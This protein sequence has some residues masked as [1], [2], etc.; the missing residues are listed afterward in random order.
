MEWLQPGEGGDT[1]ALRLP[2]RLPD[3]YGS[4][5]FDIL[6]LDSLY[7]QAPVLQLAARIGW[8]AVIALKQERRDLYRNA[9]GMFRQRPADCRFTEKRHGGSCE[10][11]IG[12]TSGLPFSKDHPQPVRVVWSQEKVTGNQYRRRKLVAETTFQEWL[13]ITTLDAGAFPAPPVRALGHDRWKNENNGWNDLTQN[14]PLKHGFLHACKHR[15]KAGA[16]A[17]AAATVGG[18]PQLTANHGL[19]AVVLI[20]CTAFVLSSAFALIHSKIM[21]LRPLS[22]LE[23][24]RQLYRSLLRMLPP[25][26]APA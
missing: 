9:M 2:A 25:I 13:W 12:D 1:A 7:P 26:R 15:P 14:W 4:R 19:A 22:L 24:A 23:V 18:I 16:A 10:V 5:F 21:R 11:Q 8:E 3:L 17:G 20:L 6:L